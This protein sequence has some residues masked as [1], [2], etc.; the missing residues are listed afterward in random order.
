MFLSPQQRINLEISQNQAQFQRDMEAASV[1][2]A[3]SPFG[4]F[5]AGLGGSFLG[6]VAKQGGKLFANSLFNRPAK[7]PK[8]G[9]GY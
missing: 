8:F 5:I 1:E 7:L 9:P 2:S 3:A 6:G 4:S